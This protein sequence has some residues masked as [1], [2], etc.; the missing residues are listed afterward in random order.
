MVLNG[1]M[2]IN[3]N[4]NNNNSNIYSNDYDEP[5]AFPKVRISRVICLFIVTENAKNQKVSDMTTD[6]NFR[7]MV[8][9]AFVCLPCQSISIWSCRLCA[10][11]SIAEAK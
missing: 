5:Q 1:N 7:Q 4:T 6:C 10:I 3:G 11:R 2:Q 8:L 9:F